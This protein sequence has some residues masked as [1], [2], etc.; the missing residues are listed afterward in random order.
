MEEV[1]SRAVAYGPGGIYT[2]MR[3][4]IYNAYIFRLRRYFFAAG[5]VQG[6]EYYCIVAWLIVYVQYIIATVIYHSIAVEV[7]Q[8]S[9]RYSRHPAVPCQHRI[10]P[11]FFF[12]KAGSALVYGGIIKSLR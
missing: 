10:L 8:H 6:V 1:S 9:L 2:E 5:T 11:V 7:P 12:I 4:H 3:L